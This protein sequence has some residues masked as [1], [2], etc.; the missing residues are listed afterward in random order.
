VVP[1][2]FVWQVRQPS[3]TA[4]SGLPPLVSV[5]HAEIVA[6][7]IGP[8]LVA[9]N[10]SK[11]KNAGNGTNEELPC[12]EDDRKLGRSAYKRRRA[13]KREREGEQAHFS[14]FAISGG[15]GHAKRST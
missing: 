14:D 2:W 1:H 3:S 13:R 8:L 6:F 12:I 11:S 5:A 10:E 9:L 7:A 15:L 4:S